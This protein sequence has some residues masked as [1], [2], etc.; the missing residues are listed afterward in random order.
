MVNRS[1]LTTVRP[2]QLYC[3]HGDN[4]ILK[5]GDDVSG[6]LILPTVLDWFNLEEF[7]LFMENFIW[8]AG[9]IR[10]GWGL[11]GGGGGPAHPG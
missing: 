11:G 10:C 5:G 1:H 7:G 3:C 2:C 8:G 4:S 9:P 6:S